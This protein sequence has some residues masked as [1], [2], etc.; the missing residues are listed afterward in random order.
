MECCVILSK[1]RFVSTGDL[2]LEKTV[3]HIEHSRGLNLR[4]CLVLRGKTVLTLTILLRPAFFS[5]DAGRV[6]TG[7]L[8][9]GFRS[10]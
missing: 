2:V 3:G 6:K 4:F 5:P 1:R 9:L 7:A 8:G 10:T